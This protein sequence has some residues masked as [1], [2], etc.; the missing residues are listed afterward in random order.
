MSLPLV[1]VRRLNSLP[2]NFSSSTSVFPASPRDLRVSIPSSASVRVSATMT[3]LP[4]AFPLALM[5]SLVPSAFMAPE[6]AV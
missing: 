4:R 6:A 5:A 2:S 3:P 1:M